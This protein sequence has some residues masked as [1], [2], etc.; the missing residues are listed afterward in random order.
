[1]IVA[2]T[3]LHILVSILL[4]LLVLI[5]GGE[6]VDITAA[7]GGVSQAA[8]GPRGAVSTMAKITWGLGAIFIATSVTLS[9]W[10]SRQ[11]S[12]S[13]LEN[14]PK[15]TTPASKA[16]APKATAPAPPQVPKK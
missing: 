14:A 10:A 15:Q 11:T 8:F 16:P 1:M 4:I 13:I 9:V 2:V 7:F 6:N 3:A 12:G 5:Q